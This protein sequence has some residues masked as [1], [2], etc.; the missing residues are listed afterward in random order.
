MTCSNTYKARRNTWRLCERSPNI[1]D[2]M[3]SRTMLNPRSLI[4]FLCAAALAGPAVAQTGGKLFKYVDA[5]GKVVYTDKLPPGAA[6]KPNEQLNGQG[7]VTK[8]NEG[9]PTPEQLA[10]QE[11]DRKRK[12]D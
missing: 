6:G 12:L 7:T 2:N 11:A 4:Y 5:N 8:R 3:E 9:A 1:D 10:T